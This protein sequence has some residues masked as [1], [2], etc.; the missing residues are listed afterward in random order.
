[1]PLKPIWS[2][3]FDRAIVTAYATKDYACRQNPSSV[4]VLVQSEVEFRAGDG[5]G[6]RFLAFGV[7]VNVQCLRRCYH[8]IGHAVARNV[9]D[10]HTSFGIG[11]RLVARRCEGADTAAT[12]VVDCALVGHEDFIDSVTGPVEEAVVAA[13]VGDNLP[14]QAAKLVQDPDWAVAGGLVVDIDDDLGSAGVGQDFAD[15]YRLEV[16]AGDLPESLAVAVDHCDVIC[17]A[18]GQDELE[19]L[20]PSALLI[21]SNTV[22]MPAGLIDLVGLEHPAE[23]AVRV[24]HC[25]AGHNLIAS[26]TVEVDRSWLVSGAVAAGVGDAPEQGASAIVGPNPMVP[27]LHEDVGRA[28]AAGEITEDKTI[29]RVVGNREPPALGAGGAVQL[30]DKAFRAKD[31]FVFAVAV[32]VVYLAGDVVVPI[33][34]SDVRVPPAPQDGTIE[35]LGDGGA[36]IVNVVIVDVFATEYFDGFVGVEVGGEDPLPTV[37]G[38]ELHNPPRRN[39]RD[40]VGRGIH[41]LDVELERAGL[42]GF[43]GCAN[44]K[45]N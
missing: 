35:L 27:V 5:G 22:E 25:V 33:L 31:D 6:I 30:N 17:T 44:R 18:A 36:G 41:I 39:H 7:F 28:I 45:D 21:D 4:V 8:H 38:V 13:V 3:I 16:A 1:V 40:I 9:A 15:V 10:K 37:F 26:V 34:A 20:R 32:P 2:F 14:Q 42:L 43:D 23:G 24:Q 12:V 29:G 19:F 11:G